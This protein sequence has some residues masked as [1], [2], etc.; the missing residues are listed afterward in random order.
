MS[1]IRIATFYQFLNGSGRPALAI[2]LWLDDGLQILASRSLEPK[3]NSQEII[4]KLN[5]TAAP[6]LKTLDLELEAGLIVDDWLKDRANEWPMSVSFLLSEAVNRAVAKTN[7]TELFK[8]LNKVYGI[9]D[10][11]YAMPT[12]I[13]NMFN[14]GAHADTNL[15]FEEFLL[16]PLS[17]N[18]Q[19]LAQ[20]IEQA[21]L[22]YREL[23]REL[24]AAGFDTDVGTFGGYAPEMT[25]S[26]EAIELMM[27]ACQAAGLVWAKDF[28]LGMDIGAKHLASGRGGYLFK[29]DHSQMMGTDLLQ[30]YEDWRRDYHLVYLEDPLAPADKANWRTLTQEL[31]DKIILAGDEFF[32]GSEVKFRQNLKDF[33]A[34]TVVIKLSQLASLTEG[35]T[36]IKLAHDHNYQVVLAADDE[37][38]EDSLV[39]DLAVAADVEYVKVGSLARLERVAKLNRLLEIEQDLIA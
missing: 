35:M 6:W 8:H 25:S 36:L 12:P 9:K 10:D 16:V 28:G 37:E 38:T 11:L 20:K 29:L 17:K 21:S 22:V 5:A 30:V 7:Q 31:G 19:S 13:F 1:K 33:S 34:N 39:A 4:D 3:T 27:R 24:K 23:G 14:G 18:Q 15:D 26:I 32:A 2:K